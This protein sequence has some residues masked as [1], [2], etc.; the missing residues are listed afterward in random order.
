MKEVRS[1]ASRVPC[2]SPSYEK[3]QGEASGPGRNQ[4]SNFC[5]H[6]LVPPPRLRLSRK[7]SVASNAYPL[8]KGCL[9]NRTAPSAFPINFSPVAFVE[10]LLA[11]IVITGIFLALTASLH[12][13]RVIPPSW[14]N[15]SLPKDQRGGL[16]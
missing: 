6:V 3:E 9:R 2:H 4:G 8:E 11:V 7:I 12:P 16:L 10:A 13:H 15:S 14:Q 5:L 1:D